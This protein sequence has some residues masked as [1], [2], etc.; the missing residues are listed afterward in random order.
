MIHQRGSG[1][2]SSLM[3]SHSWPV[4]AVPETLSISLW[5]VMVSSF[6]PQRHACR[7]IECGLV[8]GPERVGHDGKEYSDEH[9]RPQRHDEIR[10]E[11]LNRQ[12]CSHVLAFSAKISFFV[13]KLE[14]D[15]G[16]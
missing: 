2:F 6:L 15:Q 14:V 10:G 8:A 12:D 3:P 16:A 4:V 5:S 9:R 13:V 7:R 11:I 1:V